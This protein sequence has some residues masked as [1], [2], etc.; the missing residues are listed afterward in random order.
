MRV[1]QWQ[2]IV[3][4]SGVT[5]VSLRPQQ[6]KVGVQQEHAVDAMRPPPPLQRHVQGQQQALVQEAA[7]ARACK[8]ELTGIRNGKVWPAHDKAFLAVLWQA[9]EDT[10]NH[11]SNTP[12]VLSSG[13]VEKDR[14]S[15]VTPPSNADRRKDVE[16]SHSPSLGCSV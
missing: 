2:Q 8:R 16:V 9:G 14:H 12:R 13:G 6:R 11:G 5:Q 3:Y 4:E 10:F 7:Q 15:A 1:C